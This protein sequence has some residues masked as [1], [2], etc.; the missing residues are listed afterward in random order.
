VIAL[1]CNLVAEP[2]IISN[3]EYLDPTQDILH[4]LMTHYHHV[5]YNGFDKSFGDGQDM[6]YFFIALNNMNTWELAR[7]SPSEY[8]TNKNQYYRLARMM[9]SSLEHLA[10][11]KQTKSQY[12]K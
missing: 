11:E 6:E 7:I 9:E 5:K 2:T 4:L 12:L 3:L 10:V 1:L 8:F